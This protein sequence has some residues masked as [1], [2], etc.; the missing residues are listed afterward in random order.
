MTHLLDNSLK[1]LAGYTILVALLARIA[2]PAGFMPGDTS[3][4]WF[5]QLCPNGLAP[6][7]VVALLGDSHDRHHRHP[8]DER[9]G[10]DAD[11]LLSALYQAVLPADILNL[12]D[13]PLAV[14]SSSALFASPVVLTA[15]RPYRS[16]A[17]PLA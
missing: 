14:E 4:G 13:P 1:K 12:P 8:T 11:C 10:Y 16:R 5:L 6:A 7:T 17:P 15:T 3:E 2:V 9:P